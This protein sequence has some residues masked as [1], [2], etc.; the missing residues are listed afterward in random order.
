MPD[1]FPLSPLKLAVLISGAGTTLVNLLEKIA[2]GELDARVEVVVSSSADAGGLKHAGDAGIRTE[3][4]QRS[5]F[6]NVEDFSREV[7]DR[8]REAEPHLIVMGGFLKLL[9]IPEDFENRVINIHPSLIPAFCGQGYYGLRVHEAVLDYGCKTTGCTVHLVDNQ[10]DHGPI[11]LQQPVPV[12]E[13]DTPDKLA[14]R[15]FAAECELYPRA[16][17]LFAAGK[18]EVKGRNV[19]VLD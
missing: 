13:G 10:F 12:N 19:R 18:L 16:L 11:V 6:A 15:V 4:V 3:I 9:R 5:G 2:G 14:R 1:K 8:C 7:F 17:R